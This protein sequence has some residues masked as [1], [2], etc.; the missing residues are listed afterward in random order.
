MAL[1]V[2]QVD[3]EMYRRLFWAI[4]LAYVIPLLFLGVDLWR[5]KADWFPPSGAV[6]LFIVACVQFKQLSLLHNKHLYNAVR[7]ATGQPIQALS[8]QYRR[9]EW[10]SLVAALLGTVVWAYGDKLIKLTGVGG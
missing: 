8:P 2:P 10:E 4:R 9:L 5:G 1:A 6:V 7:A 3:P